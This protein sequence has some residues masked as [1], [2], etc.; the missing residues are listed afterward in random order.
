MPE[1]L[2]SVSCDLEISEND[3]DNDSL[4]WWSLRQSSPHILSRTDKDFIDMIIYSTR[5]APP[6]FSAI[7]GLG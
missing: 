6:V 5:V 2:R 1:E 7:A 3:L 4:S